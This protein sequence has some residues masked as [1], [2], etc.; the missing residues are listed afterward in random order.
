MVGSTKSRVGVQGT[1]NAVPAAG[2][3][4]GLMAFLREG[5]FERSRVRG[6]VSKWDDMHHRWWRSLGIGAMYANR[7]NEALGMERLKV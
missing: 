1:A 4:G 5:E 7:E 6:L 2:A 3:R